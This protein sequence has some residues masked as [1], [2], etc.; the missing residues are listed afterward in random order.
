MSAVNKLLAIAEA[1]VGYLEKET[2]KNLN[3]KTAN[4]GDENYTKYANDF[5]KVY[6]SF[7]NGKKNGFAWCD[8]FVDWC[9]VKAFGE[10]LALKLLGQPKK[11]CGAGCK[12]SAD[13]FKKIN[14]FFTSP[15]VGDQIF[16]ENSSGV[17]CHTGL[18]YKVDATYVYTIEGNTS[19]AAGVVANG[20]TVAKKKY[21]K[22]YASIYGYGRPDY[23][24]AE[25]E[26]ASASKGEA[27]TTAKKETASASG[28]SGSKKPTEKKPTEK[29]ATEGAKSFDKALSGTYKVTA[30]AIY[31]R[32][33][34]GIMKAILTA[35]PKG[36]AVKCFGYYTEVSGRKWLLVQFTYENVTYTGFA[37]TKY[38]AK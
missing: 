38:L 23:S 17:P 31:V 37:S 32:N 35:I 9:F 15:A 26:T 20:G 33:G 8:M 24:L 4:A 12:F 27:T 34:A 21:K 11:S 25:S 5:D 22:T 36:T 3:S 19:S 7:Y 1:E 16:F 6:T 14:R 30:S 10:A 18:V 2:N 28:S 13:Y 29:K